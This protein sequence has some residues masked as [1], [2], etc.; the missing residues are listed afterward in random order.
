MHWF[1]P[2]CGCPIDGV[3]LLMVCSVYNVSWLRTSVQMSCSA[4]DVL[5]VSIIKTG[6]L[7]SDIVPHNILALGSLLCLYCASCGYED[8]GVHEVPC[9]GFTQPLGPCLAFVL[10]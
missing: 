8:I 9:R 1:C 10:S 6:V 7:V 4:C 5:Q 2:V 3:V